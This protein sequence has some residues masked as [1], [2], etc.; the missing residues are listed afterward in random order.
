MKEP[1]KII[2]FN[3][4]HF[5]N[6]FSNILSHMDSAVQLG[7]KIGEQNIKKIFFVGCGAPHHLFMSIEYWA[8]KFASNTIFYKYFP[9]EFIAHDPA[10]L[11]ENSLVIL[12]SHSGST[13]ETVAAAAFAKNSPAQT[14]AITQSKDSHLGKAVDHVIAYGSTEEGYFSSFILT[15]SL[16]SSFLTIKESSWNFHD[17]L[18]QSLKNL[19]NVLAESKKES[20]E[21]AIEQAKLLKDVQQLY[22]IGSGPMFA[23][24][25]VFASCFLMEMQWMHAHPMQA[26]E[27]FHGPFE[28]VDQST[29]LLLLVGED[30][31]RAIAERVQHFTEQYSNNTFIYDSKYFPMSGIAPEIRPLVAPMV[32]DVALTN[33]VEA[34]AVLR[35]H[36]MTTRRYMGKVEY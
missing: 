8:S 14:L 9:A 12:G 21:T 16:L 6:Q 33:L 29:P 19:P 25:Y 3:K 23:T 18:L 27:F 32:V 5:L 24:A 36:P 20:L 34:I 17:S 2:E 31:G 7:T 35:K 13:K 28:V 1:G 11:D 26:A 30:P 15:L 22:V 10:A 4:T